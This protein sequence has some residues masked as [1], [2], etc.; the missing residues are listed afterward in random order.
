VTD[1]AVATVPAAATINAIHNEVAKP[2]L[3]R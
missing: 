2:G 3:N 1:R